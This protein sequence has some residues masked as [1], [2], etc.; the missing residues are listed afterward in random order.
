M[1]QQAKQ[2]LRKEIMLLKRSYSEKELSSFSALIME[3]LEKNTAFQEANC[4]ALYF[5]LRGEV[6]TTALLE[7]WYQEKSFLLPIVDGDDLKF[8]RYN[9]I[10]ALTVGAYG[11]LEP[12]QTAEATPI[13]AI[14]LIIVPGIAC[15]KQR[16]RM[17]R[18]KGYYDRLLTQS[19]AQKIGIC[20]DFQLKE[21]I[22]T[23][24][25]D[26]KMNQVITEKQAISE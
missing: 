23:E 12:Q 25:F 8:Y 10:D 7:K 13:E 2:L 16:N 3:R 1:T 18:G 26:I 4:I 11:I 6:E 19:S 15:D 5:P 20:F 9:G 17:G 14:D 24:I 22:P 21:E